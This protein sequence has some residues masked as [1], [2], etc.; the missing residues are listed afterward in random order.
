MD[1]KSRLSNE[2]NSA[3]SSRINRTVDPTINLLNT[4][5]SIK[6]SPRSNTPI[7]FIN[8]QIDS[9]NSILR[10]GNS[11]NVSNDAKGN[12]SS[13]ID[14]N[15]KK[16]I[17]MFDSNRDGALSN[18]EVLNYLIANKQRGKE[19]SPLIFKVAGSATD[20]VK[21]LD[22][23]DTNKD[24]KISDPELIQALL[25]LK[26]GI[27]ETSIN[28]GTAEFVL[29]KLNPN[30]AGIKEALALIDTTADQ[31][32]S[33]L[34]VLTTLLASRQ[35]TVDINNVN[36]K[37][38]LE[39]NPNFNKM[40]QALNSFSGNLSNGVLSDQDTFNIL[41]DLRK[42]NADDSVYA[43]ALFLPLNPN[44]Q[45]LEQS[46]KLFD[47][48]ADGQ[49]SDSEFV[50]AIMGMRQGY[51]SET[52]NRLALNVLD[53]IPLYKNIQN[54]IN[55]L[56]TDANGQ[57]NDDELIDFTLN[58]LK[59]NITVNDSLVSLIASSNNKEDIIKSL[60]HQIDANHNGEI[61][62]EEYLHAISNINTNNLDDK[63]KIVLSKILQ[64]NPNAAKIHSALSFIDKDHDGSINDAETA[65]ALLAKRQR[66][67]NHLDSE[68]FN[69]ILNTNE[70]KADI[71][72]LINTLDPNGDGLI[73]NQDIFNLVVGFKEG[74]VR[75][76]SNL[77]NSVLSVVPNGQETL[78]T[79]NLIDSDNDHRLS[80]REFTAALLK[81]RSGAALKPSDEVLTEFTEHI[82]N[83]D[84]VKAALEIIDKDGNGTVS[85]QEF[86]NNFSQAVTGTDGKTDLNKLAI[87]S[88]LL[89]II[90]P[91]GLALDQFRRDVDIDNNNIIT[92]TELIDAALKLNSSAIANPGQDIINVVLSSNENKDKILHL[93]D[94]IDK[95]KDGEVSLS[96][97]AQNLLK[98]RKG[99]FSA[100]DLGIVQAILSRSPYIS[101]AQNAIDIIDPD[102]NGIITNL[103]LFNALIGIHQYRNP[104]NVNS[105]PEA[106]IINELK[107]LNPNYADLENLIDKLDPDF[108]NKVNYD[109]LVAAFLKINATTLMNPG[110]DILKAIPDA[111][112]I[113]YN[114]KANKA[115]ELINTIDGDHNGT[116]S[117]LEI[118][119]IIIANKKTHTL[120][121]YDPQLV[122][123]ILRTNPHKDSID[124][125]ITSLDKNN[126][127]EFDNNEVFEALLAQYQNPNTFGSNFSLVEAILSAHNNSYDI[128]KE[129]VILFTSIDTNHDG[130][131]DKAEFGSLMVDVISN[132]KNINNYQA[133]I[134]YL[135]RDP[136]L[137]A[138]KSSIEA[139]DKD[140]DGRFSDQNILE[141]LIALDRTN[142]RAALS[143]NYIQT[144]LSTN[145]NTQ[146]IQRLLNLVD[147]LHRGVVDNNSTITHWNNVYIARATQNDM[148]YDINNNGTVDDKDVSTVVSLYKYVNRMGV[149]T[150]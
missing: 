1:S 46:V 69:M 16:Y 112:G 35:G 104:S 77:F 140:H 118:A 52:D 110:S 71:E 126:D 93:T 120:T 48:Q 43:R 55:T 75:A 144:I 15:L 138:V 96:E 17:A 5:S 68:M 60:I 53:E 92:D 12:G 42:V 61:S 11:N 73:N 117:D 121:G 150:I 85:A 136:Q 142:N 76:N 83:A 84:I 3:T 115:M 34:E 28:T 97:L 131:I 132:R 59:G 128:I 56:D 18:E 143:E 116:V 82:A 39:T 13:T 25:K 89:D 139:F 49:I 81:M 67:A 95:D 30:L 62:D 101:N 99:Q 102:Q 148:R 51:L 125:L 33:N 14:S 70:H 149:F 27:L 20:M 44:T 124:N 57:V 109:E 74:N 54:I 47:S 23:F 135:I 87:L 2:P 32:I 103:E 86:V 65:Q 22:S 63:T 6:I 36:I 94:S 129:Q 137:A 127:G 9:S 58:S 107:K 21:S 113:A 4:L 105:S 10:T 119:S 79:Y 50:T 111:N 133:I 78:D 24:L 31:N 147:P 7:T 37:K 29:G 80:L 145:S 19:P 26:A 122:E 45:A 114:T 146:Y 108:S 141:G 8:N 41:L 123:A 130:I 88:P 98:V 64:R 134:D 106:E 38:V 100:D 72:I 66:L 91:G 40:L 90:Y